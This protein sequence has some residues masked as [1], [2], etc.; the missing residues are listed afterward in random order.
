M[1]ICVKCSN[2]FKNKY[3]LA[4]HLNKKI[5]CDR[6]IKCLNCLK[7]FNTTQH[8]TRHMNRKNKCIK[9]DVEAENIE[10]KREIEELKSKQ[11]ITNNITNNNTI[12]NTQINIFT[13]EGKIYH[14]YFLKSNPLE[15]LEF[16]KG[17]LSSLTLEDYTD[18]LSNIYNFTN[19]IKEVCFNMEMPENWII[20][21][22]D[23]FNKLQLKVDNNN[24]VNCMDNIIYL[25]YTIAKQV[26]QYDELDKELILFYK[27]FISKYERGEYKDNANVKGFIKLCNEELFK[28]FTKIMNTINER[29]TRK[30]RTIET[31]ELTAFGKEELPMKMKNK[32]NEDI[33]KILET[34]YSKDFYN[35][36]FNNEGYKYSGILDIRRIDIFTYFLNTIY[37]NNSN[38]NM[39]FINNKIEIYNG[40]NWIESEMNKIVGNTF[41]N[42]W[43]LLRINKVNIDET[44]HTEDYNE[45]SYKDKVSMGYKIEENKHYGKILLGYIKGE[46]TYPEHT[47]L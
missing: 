15:E 35:K 42:I 20:C 38:R 19:L 37:S 21:K 10:L 1:F 25:I 46:Y 33:T 28:H 30:T 17:E 47:P 23:L 7:C 44:I 5:P 16:N 12:N 13:P 31:V 22:D 24:I 11:S 4:N 41:N 27:T 18:E 3:I 39:R 45:E 8:L 26:T 29:K 43:S 32:I 40:E 36:E 34:I 9:I 14:S 2:E 6:I